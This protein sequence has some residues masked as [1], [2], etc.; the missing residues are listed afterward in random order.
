M[1][2]IYDIFPFYKIYSESTILR[3]AKETP[4][5]NTLMPKLKQNQLVGMIC[6]QGI[7][8]QD[9]ETVVEVYKIYRIL[10]DHMKEAGSAIKGQMVFLQVFQ[11]LPTSDYLLK[12]P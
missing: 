6:H 12:G 3:W 11:F 8:G 9:S 2:P 1:T 10:C 5:I 4:F 7:Q